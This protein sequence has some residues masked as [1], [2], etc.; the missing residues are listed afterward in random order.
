MVALLQQLRTEEPVFGLID[1]NRILDTLLRNLMP[2]LEA[3]E[4]DCQQI[5]DTRLP[6]VKG[7]SSQLKEAFNNLIT[8]AVD[9]MEGGVF[10]RLKL[11]IYQSPRRSKSPLS[12]QGLA[13]RMKFAISSTN[14]DIP[15]NDTGA[16]SV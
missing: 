7:D 3:K 13:S 10:S 12:I 8:N 16:D 2:V 9:A 1:I 14:P 6:S 15:S 11:P 4:I 5:F